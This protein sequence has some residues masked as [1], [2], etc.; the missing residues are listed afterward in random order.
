M[1]NDWRSAAR[2]RVKEKKQGA[3]F[4]LVEGTNAFRIL[5]NKKDITATGTID[6]KKGLQYPPF[7]EFRVHRDVGPDKA[8]LACGHDIEGGGSCWLCDVKIPELEKIPTKRDQAFEIGP[9]ESFLI[10][11]SR[12]D[13]ETGKFSMPKPFWVSNG[14]GIVGRPAKRPTLATQVQSAILN[15]RKDFID[16]V[17]GYNMYIE[18]TGLGQKD[19][20]YGSP[21]GDEKASKVPTAI[22]LAVKSFEELVP[23]Y[24]VEEQK[25]AYY[26]RPKK[27]AE[28]EPED[29]EVS[30]DTDNEIAAEDEEVVEGEEAATEEISEEKAPLD[31]E[32]EPED[33]LPEEEAPLDEEPEPEMEVEEEPPPTRPVRRTTPSAAPPRKMTPAPVPPKKTGGPVKKMP[34]PTT[35]RR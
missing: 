32:P 30:E 10:Q 26:G 9:R 5:P 25:S 12:I 2:E 20:T 15:S 34:P 23:A 33:M 7:L 24:D 28:V 18:R 13:G 11:V 29:E 35:K 27:E 16:P 31:E 19:T 22:L 17:K 3:S 4:K 6:P 21:E 1:S 14:R 8:F